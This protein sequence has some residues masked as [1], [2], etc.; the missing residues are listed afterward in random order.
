MLIS[1]VDDGFFPLSYKGGK[2][3]SP[4]VVT[5]FE[6][7]TF[8][9]VN[10]GFITVDGSDAK[11][12]FCKINWGVTTIFDGVTFAGFNY[13]IP[14]KNYIIFYGYRPNVAKVKLA[15]DKHFHDDREE[16]IISILERLVRIES[17]WGPVY[18]YTDL[19][20]TLA[21]NLIDKYQV[22]SKYP[23]PIRY[24]HVIG[25]ALGHWHARC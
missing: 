18:L 12:A 10:L 7:L 6:D 24:A 21:R 20:L 8:K 14:D 5:L 25:K 9:D 22:I 2:G 13:I 17:R 19:D 1:G 4:L 15:L 23:E 16:K 3:K 11:E